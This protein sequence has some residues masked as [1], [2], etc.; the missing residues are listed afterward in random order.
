MFSFLFLPREKI[1]DFHPR[2]LNRVAM[3]ETNPHYHEKKAYVFNH[4]CRLEEGVDQALWLT[5]SKL[6]GDGQVRILRSHFS[7]PF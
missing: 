2:Y 3:D 7:A 4:R 6:M 5:K 1:A